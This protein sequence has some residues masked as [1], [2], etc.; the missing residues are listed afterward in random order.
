MEGH[1][2]DSVSGGGGLTRVSL[3]A[4]EPDLCE[5]VPKLCCELPACWAFPGLFSH[6]WIK[7]DALLL[8]PCLVEEEGTISAFD[9]GERCQHHWGAAR[10]DFQALPKLFH[11]LCRS[12]L[13]RR[14]AWSSEQTW[15]CVRQ[16]LACGGTG[17]QACGPRLDCSATWLSSYPPGTDCSVN[18]YLAP[19]VVQ[20]H[21]PVPHP[22]RCFSLKQEDCSQDWAPSEAFP[23]LTQPTWRLERKN[24]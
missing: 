22:D 1:S 4:P 12:H 8:G 24:L 2:W 16:C 11:S 7:L 14:M 13:S 17:G 21:S 5:E 9:P 18:S 23:W 6:L 20:Q 15:H 19:P 10:S 3:V